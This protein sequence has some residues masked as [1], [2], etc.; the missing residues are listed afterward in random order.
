MISGQ[1]IKDINLSWLHHFSQALDGQV[2]YIYQTCD[3]RTGSSSE[4][5]MAD[6]FVILSPMT[7]WGQSDDGLGLT[8]IF[9]LAVIVRQAPGERLKAFS[10]IVDIQMIVE[11]ALYGSERL[12][13]TSMDAPEY[14]I[15]FLAFSEDG[16]PVGEINPEGLQ[17]LR[18]TWLDR[19]P[20]GELVQS[21]TTSLTVTAY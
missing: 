11:Q 6:E 20:D 13:V 9:Q 17:Y 14:A 7:S 4:L 15:P 2:E 16:D 3:L 12:L 1:D 18:G 8:V 5:S 19:T 10:R 21:W